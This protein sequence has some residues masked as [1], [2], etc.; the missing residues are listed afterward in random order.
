MSITYEISCRVKEGKLFTIEAPWGPTQK[1]RQLYVA[2]DIQET[3]IDPPDG[4]TERFDEL[5]ADLASFSTMTCIDAPFIRPL[6]PPGHGVWAIRSH[7][8]EPQ[9]RVFGHFA[10]KDV[11]VAMCLDYRDDLGNVEDFR[12]DEN[13]QKTQDGWIALFKGRAPYTG[14]KPASTSLSRAASDRW[15]RISRSASRS[16]R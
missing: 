7:R 3:L 4:E 11:F 12:W 8:E 9:I 2:E 5:R 1:I 13:I 14:S 10:E 15:I 16:C 6:K